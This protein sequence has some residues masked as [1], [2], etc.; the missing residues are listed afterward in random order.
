MKPFIL[1]ALGSIAALSAQ[2][3]PHAAWQ[4]T[5]DI[6]VPGP[7]LVR[8]EVPAATASASAPGLDDLRLVS[9]QGIETPYTIEWPQLATVQATAVAAFRA[10]L[11]DHKTLLELEPG[12]D[13][14]L[15]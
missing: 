7:G 10:S 4:Q 15:R 1:L 13:K 2:A 5:Q 14:A 11:T 6:A 3:E 12:T 9:P 8:F